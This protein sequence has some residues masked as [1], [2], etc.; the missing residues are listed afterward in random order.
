MHLFT[1]SP[2]FLFYAQN[3][4]RDQPLDKIVQFMSSPLPTKLKRVISAAILVHNH[5]MAVIII[6]LDIFVS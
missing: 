3:I 4:A 2:L 6:Q 1:I 5:K